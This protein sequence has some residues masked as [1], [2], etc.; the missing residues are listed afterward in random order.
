MMTDEQ[1]QKRAEK[2]ARARA[3]A[4]RL[5][6]EA[7]EAQFVKD[8]AALGSIPDEKRRIFDYIRKEIASGR[9]SP[10]DVEFLRQTRALHFREVSRHSQGRK[11]AAA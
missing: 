2:A 11:E 10:E 7:I 8:L 6:S 4:A 5:R 9:R 3:E 1:K